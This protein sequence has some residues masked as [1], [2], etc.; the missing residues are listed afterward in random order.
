MYSEDPNSL[1]EKLSSAVKTLTDKQGKF[2]EKRRRYVKEQKTWFPLYVYVS[3]IVIFAYV[4]Y[5]SVSVS[6]FV[7]LPRFELTVESAISISI[8]AAIIPLIA[9]ALADN[10][11]TQQKNDELAAD[12][13]EMRI[14]LREVTTLQS[15]V[16]ESSR[17][18]PTKQ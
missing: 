16:Y 11:R 13:L 4:L 17:S 2:V 12:F 3:S 18:S 6:Y 1:M 7:E 15:L 5:A 8:A 9:F 14:L 10:F